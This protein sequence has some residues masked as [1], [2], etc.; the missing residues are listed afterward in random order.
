MNH[1]L[2]EEIT[3]IMM[4][5]YS[6]INDLVNSRYNML[7]MED[8]DL[9][10]VCDE[11]EKTRLQFKNLF[12][13]YE[14]LKEELIDTIERKSLCQDCNYCYSVVGD[15]VEG[16]ETYYFQ[17]LAGK[18]SLSQIRRTMEHKLPIVNIC[19]QYKHDV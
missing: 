18:N 10:F 3:K 12:D 13:K 7:K 1:K 6:T 16:G 5:L 17:C 2:I 8:S 4:D 11:I 19:S 14:E 9:D 15:C